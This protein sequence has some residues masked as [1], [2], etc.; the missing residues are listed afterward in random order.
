MRE[1]A[2][3]EGAKS[4]RHASCVAKYGISAKTA[5]VEGRYQ[6][7]DTALA[8]RCWRPVFSPSRIEADDEA[9]LVELRQVQ[10]AWD[11]P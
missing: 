2:G 1:V 11:P 9:T 4:T 10:P 6:Q 7:A 8:A 5:H 3:Q